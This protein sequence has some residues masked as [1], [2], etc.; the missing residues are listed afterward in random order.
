MMNKKGSGTMTGVFIT[1]ILT[2]A[3]F[4]GGYNY[5]DSNYDDV[6]TTIPLGYN[7]SFADLETSQGLLNE[8]VNDIKTSVQGI[9]EADGDVVSV[10]WNGLTGVAATLRLFINVINVGIDVFNALL[11]GLSFIPGWAKVLIEMAIVISVVMILLGAFKGEAK[12]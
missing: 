7:Q 2:M 6:N 4:Y 12:T 8:S 10:A 1:I 5:I 11:P 9:A 3:L